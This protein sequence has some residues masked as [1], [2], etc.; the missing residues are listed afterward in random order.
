[1][2]TC[3][4][5]PP[6]DS[7]VGRRCKK[8]KPGR[9]RTYLRA[10]HAVRSLARWRSDSASSPNPSDSTLR[11]EV[12]HCY[13]GGSGEKIRRGMR[14]RRSKKIFSLP[15]RARETDRIDPCRRWWSSANHFFSDRPDNR[16]YE[17]NMSWLPWRE[18]EGRSRHPSPSP[19]FRLTGRV[20]AQR[21][22]DEP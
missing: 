15:P 10:R 9:S 2:S 21:N 5:R 14:E 6:E 19:L 22:V 18:A 17:Y 11:F 12:R 1:M 3:A 13:F 8:K 20:P 7:P 16:C 4:I